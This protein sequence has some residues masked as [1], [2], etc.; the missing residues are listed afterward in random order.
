[1]RFIEAID[2]ARRFGAKAPDLHEDD[3]RAALQ[4]GND[5]G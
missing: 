2:M 1:M 3:P 4:F 5:A